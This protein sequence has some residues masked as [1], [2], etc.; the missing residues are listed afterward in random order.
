M[1]EEDQKLNLCSMCVGF[2]MSY[3]TRDSILLEWVTKCIQ[4]AIIPIKVSHG[5]IHDMN[6]FCKFSHLHMRSDIIPDFHI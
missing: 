3:K 6:I 4:F 5:I 2:F 1:A